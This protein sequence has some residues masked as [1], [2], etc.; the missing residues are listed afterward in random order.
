MFRFFSPLA[1]AMALWASPAAASDLLVAPTR[2]VFD[3]PR[4]TEVV[5]NNIGSQPATYRIS[6]EIKRM[7]AA[8]GLVD[9]PEAEQ[10]DSERAAAA[11]I[12]FSP[13][14][15]TL[16]PN[17]P[18]VIRVGVRLPEGLNPG[19]Y[20]AHMLFRAVPDTAP[21]VRSPDA[22][23]P[24]GVS[25][26]LTP[27]YGI[28]IPVIVRVGELRATAEIGRS[29]VSTDGENGA[30]NFELN[31]VGDRSV[32]GDI[33]VR[34]AGVADP[35]LLARGIA[36][37]PEIA[38]RKVSIPVPQELAAALRGPVTIRY[39]EDRELGGGTISQRELVV[40]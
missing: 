8:G 5:L 40:E 24:A 10:T 26:S 16:P 6:L 17:Q 3:S 33:E 32:Y 12:S 27:I 15:V 34:R 22:P 9:V 2:V 13:R 35:L 20:R 28:T 23:A 30:F 31:R 39:T 25:I 38:A 21:V 36:V 4:G 19:E 11:M 14:R 1:I 18:Q 7:T 37:Y 29:W